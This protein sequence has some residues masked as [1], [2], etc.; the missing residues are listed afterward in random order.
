MELFL[1]YLNSNYEIISMISASNIQWRRKYYECGS[2]SIQIQPNVY[3][4]T[5]KYIWT[6]HRPEL[7]VITQVNYIKSKR[8]IYIQLSGYFAE[9]L[10]DQAVCLDTAD[11]S[12]DDV[13]VGLTNF[14]KLYYESCKCTP[15]II[16]NSPTISG[17]ATSFNAIGENIGTKIYS[18]GKMHQI[19][20]NIVL[21]SSGLEFNMWKGVD[22]SIN[23]SENNPVVFSNNFN[24][25]N[26][27]NMLISNT[28][29]KNKFLAKIKGSLVGSEDDYKYMYTSDIPDNPKWIMIDGTS[30]E[31]TYDSAIEFC[32]NDLENSYGLTLDLDFNADDTNYK[33]LKDFDLGD[34]ITVLLPEINIQEDARIIE[35]N[36]V[37][38]KNS[39]TI[40]IKFGNTNI[41]KS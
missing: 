15:N 7:G 14:G 25:L 3:D 16:F 32:K 6:P 23:Q 2:F 29:Y 19:S 35:I 40:S 5:A 39:H 36:E 17:T 8:E 38:K 9:S 26:N 41:V 12:N 33:Y 37:F 4:S 31:T 34:I 11:I 22:R 13:C 24:V 28:N 10:L 1:F 21:G 18:I 27:I 30:V 20:H